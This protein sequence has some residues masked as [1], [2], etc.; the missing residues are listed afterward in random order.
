MD[1]FKLLGTIVIDNSNANK[2]LDDTA[3]RAKGAADN[4]GAVSDSGNKTSSK[5]AT[6][7]GKVGS[8]AVKVGKVVATGIAAAGTAIGGITVKAL[9]A[10]GELEQNMG[11]SEA[12]F[13]DYAERMQNKAKTAFSEMGLS[14][15]DFLGTANKMGALFQGAGFGIEDRKSVV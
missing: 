11:G 2:A 15:S 3:S 7:M 5:F 13:G 4:V 9:S 1:L 6:A 10:A 12:V 8:A 14:A